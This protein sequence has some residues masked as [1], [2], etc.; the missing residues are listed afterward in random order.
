MYPGPA[1]PPPCSPS[2]PPQ[3]LDDAEAAYWAQR[4]EQEA[5][6]AAAAGG[7]EGDGDGMAVDAVWAP[8][9]GPLT[10]SSSAAPGGPG[11]PEPVLCPVC[12]GCALVELHGV[13]ACPAERW[14]LDGRA[15]GLGLPQLRQQL[16]CLF[17]VGPPRRGYLRQSA[18]RMGACTYALL[19]LPHGWSLGYS[20]G[21]LSE[22]L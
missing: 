10:P 22:C 13:V 3:A 20:G 2:R 5:A 11:G 18:T 14:Q 15:D 6:E 21:G 7:G 16:A 9:G 4:A 8:G 17:E 12:C 19:S 1:W